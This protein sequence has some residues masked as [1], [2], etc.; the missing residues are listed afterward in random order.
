MDSHGQIIP[1]HR[2]T[3]NI[4]VVSPSPRPHLLIPGEGWGFGGVRVVGE[5][6]GWGGGGGRGDRWKGREVTE[7]NG[8][9]CVFV[10]KQVVLLN[11]LGCRLTY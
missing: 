11:V 9:C 4:E 6:G 10:S 7:V 1:F 2:A 5:G 8:S 3:R